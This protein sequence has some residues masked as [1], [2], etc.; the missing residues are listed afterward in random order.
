MRMSSK[1][2]ASPRGIQGGWWTQTVKRRLR[3]K[4]VVQAMVDAGTVVLLQETHWTR[5]TAAMWASGVF[6]HTA[7]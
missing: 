4:A 3:K 1:C 5:T 6:P 2:G 7:I